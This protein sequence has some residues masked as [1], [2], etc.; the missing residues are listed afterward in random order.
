MPRCKLRHLGYSVFVSCHIVVHYDIS[1]HLNSDSV[2]WKEATFR[3]V[4][5]SEFRQSF[6]QAYGTGSVETF[7]L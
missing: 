7:L 4:I 2:L 6:Y 5:I 3:H 1:F